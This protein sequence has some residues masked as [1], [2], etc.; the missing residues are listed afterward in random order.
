M[1]QVG[2]GNEQRIDMLH[3]FRPEQAGNTVQA[4]PG[5]PEGPRIIQQ[6]APTRRL[7]QHARPMPHVDKGTNEFGL[8]WGPL[9]V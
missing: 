5:R 7:D 4:E 2:M 3:L 9:P 8:M 6:V 1:I